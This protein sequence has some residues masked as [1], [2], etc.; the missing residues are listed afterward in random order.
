MWRL[1]A[2]EPKMPLLHIIIKVPAS[3]HAAVV[4]FY[5]QAREHLGSKKLR[6]YS[7]G[8]TGFGRKSLEMLAG[9]NDADT[10]ISPKIH[11]GFV[12]RGKLTSP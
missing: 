7:N 12:A 5:S 6:T 10:K 3:E 9:I 8:T 4:K 2:L 11:I 1:P